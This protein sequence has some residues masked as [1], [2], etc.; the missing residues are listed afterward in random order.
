MSKSAALIRLESAKSDIKPNPFN[1]FVL[2]FGKQYIGRENSSDLRIDS[3]EISRR[4]A[5]IEYLDNKW[6]IKDLEV[7]NIC[8]N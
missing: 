8:F 2:N 7:I 1:G 4:H 5:V 3:I 6:F